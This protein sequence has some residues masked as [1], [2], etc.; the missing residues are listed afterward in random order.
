MDDLTASV[1][2][3][4]IPISLIEPD[5]DNPRKEFADL[6]KTAAGF[7]ANF[8]NPGEPFNPPIV[9]RDGDG[10][11]LVD[12]E[13]RW[14]AMR[15]AGKLEECHA[16][17]CANVGAA[18][19]IL[20]MLA[21]DDKRRLTDNERDEGVQLALKLG[22]KPAE[23]EKAAGMKR[24]TGK[25]ILAGMSAAG[26]REYR[27]QT[28]EA[29]L[30]TL[31][32]KGDEEILDL[33]AGY[34]GPNLRRAVDQAVR[35]RERTAARAAVVGALEA[36]GVP[37][38]GR[39]PPGARLVEEVRPDGELAGFADRV[40]ARAGD[41]GV[42]FAV[43]PSDPDAIAWEGVSLYSAPKPGAK[44]ES[45]NAAGK[46]HSAARRRRAEWAS[47]RLLDDGWEAA[48]PNVCALVREWV[49]S[50]GAGGAAEFFRRAGIEAPDGFGGLCPL[51]VAQAWPLLDDLTIPVAGD[52]ACGAKTGSSLTKAGL[53]A[54][55]RRYDALLTALEADGYRPD[56]PEARLL[57][58]CRARIA[59][60]G[61]GD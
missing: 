31:E 22:V 16:L 36:A 32:H 24:G 12:G 55:A 38:G 49:A 8:I 54:A 37:H 42:G 15:A 3:E 35:R 33:I 26:G 30:L 47:S 27:Q 59:P 48:M 41:G 53:D 20:A 18:E 60:E 14:R 5:P 23:V 57:A 39:I 21:T 52:L 25:R 56:E 43:V 2:Y 19:A 61:G 50:A 58:A 6:D 46:A 51:V 1:S 4:R 9:V 28:T 45:A 7:E 11:R 40:A 17:V 10:Y 13:R 29:Y 44:V 34:D